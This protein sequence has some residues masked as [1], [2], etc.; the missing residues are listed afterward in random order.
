MLTATANYLGPA[1]VM[2]AEKATRKVEVL[3]PTGERSRAQSAL[4][5]PYTA[6]EGDE[7]LVLGNHLDDLF[8]IG[9]L[10]GSGTTT[11]S[12]PADLNIEAPNGSIRLACSTTLEFFGGQRAEISAPRL[13]LRAT[14]LDLVAKRSIQKFT[15]VYA[16]VTELFQ[17]KSKRTRLVSTEAHLVK[18]DRVHMR[19][20]GNFSINAETIHLG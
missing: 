13:L 5:F 11:L 4:A 17:L 12:V 2:A 7:V 19:T 14:R 1:T 10:R 3:L 9:V 18:A 16:W 20:K 6:S 8:V 15:N